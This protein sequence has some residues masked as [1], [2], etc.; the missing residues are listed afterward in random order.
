MPLAPRSGD[1]Q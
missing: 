1:T